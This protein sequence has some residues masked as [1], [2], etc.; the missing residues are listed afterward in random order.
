MVIELPKQVKQIIDTLQEQGFEAYAV[1][2]CVRDAMLGKEP[3]DWDITTSALPKQVKALFRRTIDTGIQHGTVTVLLDKVGYEVTT[4]RVDG[5][6]EDGRHPTEVSF[7]AS[8]TE[9]LKRRDFTINAMAYNE[10]DGLVDLFRGKEDLEKGIIRCVGVAK[11]RFSED[12][13]RILRA[14]RFSAQ[15]DFS[16][17]EETLEAARELAGTLRKISAE[18]IYAELTKLLLSDHPGRLL[19]VYEYDV[20]EIILPEFDR[21]FETPQHHP[22]HYANVGLHV[23]DTVQF[24]RR[25][26]EY[27]GEGGFTKDEFRYLRLAALFHDVGKPE[28]RETDEAG[29][30][31]F[32]G[33]AEPGAELA[34]KI[35][36]RLKADNATID[37]VSRLVRWHDYPFVPE[38]R[39]LRRAM[40]KIG[41]DLFPLLL[42]LRRGDLAAH[43]EPYRSSGPEQMQ[44]VWQAYLGIKNREECTSLKDLAVNGSDLIAAGFAPGK[45]LGEVLNRLLLLVIE[46]PEKNQKEILLAE[47]VKMTGK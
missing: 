32:Y 7:T 9:D 21:M 46:E 36:R 22:A 8:L 16:I 13:L 30:D 4:Y 45:E 44:K 31:H 5:A 38:E 29:V 42:E 27:A 19:T 26:S 24:V 39:P 14:F 12:A 3:Q 35:L 20:T 28:C 10:R 6:Y 37:T 15:L 43:A 40:H 11:E 1:G 33:H 23:L 41:A 17:E 2:G 25:M 34:K 18:R 47:A